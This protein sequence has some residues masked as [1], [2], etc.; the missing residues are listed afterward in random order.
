MQQNYCNWFY[1]AVRNVHSGFFIFQGLLALTSTALDWPWSHSN[2]N[3]S[4][5][6]LFWSLYMI[7]LGQGG[8]NPSLQAFGADQLN[9]EDELPSTKADEDENS[10]KKSLFFQWWYFGICIGSLMG[11]S[12]LA[13]IQDTLGWGL[14]FAI[15]TIAMVTS[16]ILF[17]CGTKFYAY[18]Q[19][20]TVDMKFISKV[21]QNVKATALRMIRMRKGGIILSNSNS[22]V[23]ELE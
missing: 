9:I 7:S 4:S 18:K 14:G 10:E 20:K 22:D 6:S 1:E 15:P 19:A 11:I 3:R 2:G 13:Y 17:S 5:L 16:I 21:Y 23:I 12:L 8:Y